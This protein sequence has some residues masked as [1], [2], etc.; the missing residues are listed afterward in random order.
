[1]LG[2][3]NFDKYLK[4]GETYRP[5]TWRSVLSIDLLE[6]YNFLSLFNKLFSN[7]FLF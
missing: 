6:H 7:H 4:N 1:M 3:E 2:T 5:K